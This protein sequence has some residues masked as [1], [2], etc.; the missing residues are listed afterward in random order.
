MPFFIPYP[1]HLSSWV[2]ALHVL[3]LFV[4][5]FGCQHCTTA[6][7]LY[8]RTM[9]CLGCKGR[10]KNESGLIRHLSKKPLCQNAMG[11]VVPPIH[12][13]IQTFAL[14]SP[15]HNV[16]PKTKRPA[17]PHLPNGLYIPTSGK[18]R[19]TSGLS[20]CGHTNDT[21][22]TSDRNKLSSSMDSHVLHSMLT[23]L[24]TDKRVVYDN[25]VRTAHH[26]ISVAGPSSTEATIEFSPDSDTDDEDDAMANNDH[27]TTASDGDGDGEEV[28]APHNNPFANDF[29]DAPN[30]VNTGAVFHETDTAFADRFN[31]AF[32]HTEKLS[33]RLLSILRRIGAPNY[34]YGEIMEIMEDALRHNV[35]LT[36]TF[37]DR[38]LT[39]NHL[40]QRFSMQPL[41]PQLDSIGSPDGRVFA[42][43]TH[44]AKS[45]IHSLLT[46]PLMEDD[47]NLLFPN[48]EDPLAPPPP[49]VLTL[50]DIDTGRSYR[51]AYNLLCRGRPKHIM[52]GIILYI[53]KLA[54]D[55]HGHLSLEPVYF[56]LSIFNQ[57]TRNKPEAWRPLGY[58]PNLGLQSKAENRHS[59]LSSQ[60]VQ[61]Y[62]DILS[63]ILRSLVE[64]QQSEPMPFHLSFGNREY[65]VLLKFPLLAILGDTES[66]D[67]LCGR[68]NMRGINTARL[69]RHCD[70]PT[71]ETANVDYL[72]R[73]IIP[74]DIKTLLAAD[75]LQGLKNISQHPIRN[76]F[77]DGVCLGGNRRG[78][79][80]MSPAEPLHLLELGLFKYAIEGFCVNLG[81]SPKSK[82]YP[83][84]IKDLDDWARR[85]GRYLGHQSDRALPRT[86]FPNGISGGTKL[87]GHEMNGVL[88]VLLIL[89]NLESSKRLL[90][91][92]MTEYQLRGW[93]A[94]LEMLLAWRWWLKRP[95][96]P[97]MIVVA[98]KHC[99]KDLM[100]LFKRVVNRKH[101]SGLILIKFHICL[102]FFENNLDLGVTS[103]FDTGPM[104]SNHKINAKNPSKRTQM[105]A[106]GFE[107]GTA[108]RY[109]EDLILDVATHE[110][111]RVS[112]IVEKRRPP[113]SQE[114][115]QLQGAKYTITYGAETPN[116]DLGGIAT[117]EWD[118]RHIVANGYHGEHI[119]WLC[120]NLLSD[121]GE[122]AA[123][124][125]CTEHTRVTGRGG[126]YIFRAHPAYR[127][128]TFW[129]DWALF[130]WGAPGDEIELVPGHIVTFLY[131]SLSDIHLLE[132]NEHVVGSE[133]GLYAMVESLEEPLQPSQKYSRLTSISSKYL[134]NQ[135]RIN[136]RNA[137]IPLTRSNTY[138]VPV[139][140][141]YEPIAAIPNAGGPDG[142]FLFI[143]PV[144]DWGFEFS[145]ILTQYLPDETTAAA[146]PQQ[147]PNV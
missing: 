43:V 83:K 7:Q 132:D 9:Q 57:K 51:N 140:T 66:H 35:F 122:L 121:L 110:L 93:V 48:L 24:L 106:V 114:L 58:I 67:R 131:L 26:D 120:N 146:P 91:T 55:R 56:T 52:C 112:P 54:V 78:V 60:K 17:P 2:T 16:H 68:Y 6:L 29:F 97:M 105:R 31:G 4:F 133:P 118:Q 49:I 22:A 124:R 69:C 44:R 10:F 71:H 84:I 5:L 130:Q 96:L 143:R 25:M 137:R 33:I 8:F 47:T 88:L 46:S 20:S 63:R 115:S 40:A 94:L 89:C 53:D 138:L 11:I 82:S 98:A 135:Q 19:K 101:G 87:A 102:H 85:I 142:D 37:R 139:D 1:S 81:Y 70:T 128:G 103:N 74:D 126:R 15:P 111:S 36:S 108:H 104:E 41:F 99:V 141:I 129:H 39:L 123:I 72:W 100:K 14:E 76:A 23:T 21:T 32:S 80:G 59:M 117:L 30:T 125:G 145:K 28:N 136:R 109:I 90:L 38:S 13:P 144:D 147:L 64:L 95:T 116:H 75:D 77:Y 113:S 42:L 127:G 107:E 50:A 18:G 12:P 34:V 73:H 119:Q 65:D 3:I 86:Y 61:L 134:T 62:H 92:K 45:M 79:H 27:H